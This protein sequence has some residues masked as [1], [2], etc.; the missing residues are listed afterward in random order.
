MR[1]E[2]KYMPDIPFIS[3]PPTPETGLEN[4]MSSFGAKMSLALLSILTKEVLFMVP[5]EA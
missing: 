4:V 1:N 3:K 2:F 5:L